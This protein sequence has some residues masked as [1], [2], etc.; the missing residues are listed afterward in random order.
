MAN[1]CFFNGFWANTHLNLPYLTKAN[2]MNFVP[3]WKE[4][5]SNLREIGLGRQSTILST[6][7]S[8]LL[9]PDQMIRTLRSSPTRP[10]M[11]KLKWIIC[12]QRSW[13]TLH[14]RWLLGTTST[15]GRGAE[16]RGDE[17]RRKEDIQTEGLSLRLHSNISSENCFAPMRISS[18]YEV[19]N[20]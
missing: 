7:Y 10:F 9:P 11:N 17:G 18:H 16:A 5:S 3:S 8:L 2:M 14:C 13:L 4:S 15:P 20:T 1:H 19:K 6:D 12:F